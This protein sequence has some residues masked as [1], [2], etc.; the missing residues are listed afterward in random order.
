MREAGDI[1]TE[2]VNQTDV[3]VEAIATKQ[4]VKLAGYSHLSQLK[5]TAELRLAAFAVLISSSLDVSKGQW[6]GTSGNP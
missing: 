1:S 5:A 4:E 2:L 6:N 3:D